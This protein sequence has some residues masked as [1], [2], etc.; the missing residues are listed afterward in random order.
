M[1][2]IWGASEAVR[3]RANQACWQQKRGQLFCRSL[4]RMHAMQLFTALMG[5]HHQG[6]YLCSPV[7][8]SVDVGYKREKKEGREGAETGLW[9]TEGWHCPPIPYSS[10]LFLHFSHLS[11]F[12]H[13]PGMSPIFLFSN[14]CLSKL[15]QQVEIVLISICICNLM[16]F[17][18]DT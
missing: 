2:T 5:N 18:R 11:L 9:P 12:S 6:F 8:W 13:I 7:V 14:C 3:Q 15:C 1:W 10:L 16:G 4:M 17:S